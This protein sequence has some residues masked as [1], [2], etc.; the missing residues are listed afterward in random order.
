MFKLLELARCKSRCPANDVAMVLTMLYGSDSASNFDQQMSQ[1]SNNTT[2]SF[3]SRG[4][5]VMTLGQPFSVPQNT[6]KLNATVV[7]QDASKQTLDTMG[8][9]CLRLKVLM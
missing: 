4:I 9:I 1:P 7:S 6:L 5:T 2:Y 3:P 8:M